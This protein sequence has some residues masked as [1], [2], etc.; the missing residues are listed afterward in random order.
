MVG[1]ILARYMV[2]LTLIPWLL[3]DFCVVITMI[4]FNSVWKI[5]STTI[6]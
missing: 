1:S 6:L 5:V 4:T 3:L 2:G